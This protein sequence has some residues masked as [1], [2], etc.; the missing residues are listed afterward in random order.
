VTISNWFTD[1]DNRIEYIQPYGGSGISAAQIEAM[2]AT[3]PPAGDFDTVVEGTTAAEQLV[4]TSGADQLNAYEGD[5]QL[6]GLAGDDELNGGPGSDYLDGGAGNDVQ[7]GG[8]GADQLG[9]DA[10]DDI[11]TG[12]SDDDI[13]IYRAG[14]GADTIVNAG[15]GIDW[16]IFN[17]N[18]TSDRLSFI[19]SND[20]LI[21]R[22]DAD[23]ATQITVSDWF[24]GG[25]NQ[26]SYIQ[27]YGESGI[28]AAQINALFTV[29]ADDDN[30]LLTVP[31]EST[32]DQVVT[33]VAAGGQV[34]G[35]NGNDLLQGLEGDDQLFGLGGN[36]WLVA[37]DGSDYLDGGT[38]NDTQLGGAGDDQL[39]GD[40]GDDVLSG[41]T[42]NDLYVYR[43]GSGNDTIVN[44]DGGTDWLIFA[45]DITEDRLTYVQSGDDLL[46]NIDDGTAGSV[47]VLDWFLGPEH[48][49]SY[50]QPSG[51]YGIPGA[52]LPIEQE[53]TSS[54]EETGS[55]LVL[56]D[57]VSGEDV[58][59]LSKSVFTSLTDEGTLSSAL[60]C[61]NS[62]GS[63]QD[64]NDYILYNTSSGALLYDA[65]G[66][67][68]G[69]AVQ[70]ASLSNK[71]EISANDFLVV[72]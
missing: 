71:P 62:T 67:G 9:G 57:F 59:Q 72:A 7:N 26:L 3:D 18:I 13:Y 69:A 24:L 12:G 44:G 40:A 22:I 21:I 36:D 5:D 30:D 17:D 23:S 48:Q 70:F 6:F 42:G 41:G 54:T 64:D 39:G 47:T 35:A 46:V 60:F 52:S 43:A 10:G 32:F 56:S 55:V 33:G 28:S 63:A 34:V 58:L 14:A 65:D 38:G 45:D 31:D 53:S 50:I 25:E 68:E 19:Q 11:L 66:S 2:L 29:P 20:D 1:T 16:L 49:L 37:G 27:P 15:G 8:A 4:G 61:A 51:G